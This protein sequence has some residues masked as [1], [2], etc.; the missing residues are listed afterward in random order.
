MPIETSAAASIS[1]I[2]LALRIRVCS[3]IVG[4]ACCTSRNVVRADEA[5][6]GLTRTAIRM[7]FGT[8]SCSRRSRFAATSSTKKLMP[9]AL[10]PGRARLATRPSGTG[11]SATPKTIGVFRGH[12]LN[13]PTVDYLRRSTR[14]NRETI[15]VADLGFFKV[16][17]GFTGVFPRWKLLEKTKG[18]RKQGYF[19]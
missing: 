11:S 15:R 10:P 2:V 9:V 19:Q 13:S 7:A 4:A 16:S 6:A 18:N 5:L 14:A 17:S 12:E 8:K 1:P 3:P